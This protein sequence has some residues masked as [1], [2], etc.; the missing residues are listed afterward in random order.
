MVAIDEINFVLISVGMTEIRFE[1]RL[2]IP[3]LCYL[4]VLN[5]HDLLVALKSVVCPKNRDFSFLA[6]T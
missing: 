6:S 5:L 4:I 3:F 2:N 1:I